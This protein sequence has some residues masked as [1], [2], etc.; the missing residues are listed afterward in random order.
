M[1]LPAALVGYLEVVAGE[2][3]PTCEYCV[4]LDTTED[5]RRHA[6]RP[7]CVPEPSDTN[8]SDTD[9]SGVYTPYVVEADKRA[10]CGEFVTFRSRVD[11]EG[12]RLI[13]PNKEEVTDGDL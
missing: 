13:Q 1:E 5:C 12:K 8:T 10:A 11:F 3:W 4:F 9:F 7:A 6:P 2:I